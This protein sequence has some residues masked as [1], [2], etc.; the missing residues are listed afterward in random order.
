MHKRYLQSR[1]QSKIFKFFFL[2]VVVFS[3]LYLA[4]PGKVTEAQEKSSDAEKFR[5]R[6]SKQPPHSPEMLRMET[7]FDNQ[8]SSCHHKLAD[9]H[10]PWAHSMKPPGPA[11]LTMIRQ[12]PSM[13]ASIIINGVPGT[14]MPAHP[15]LDMETIFGLMAYI[16]TKPKNTKIQWNMPWEISSAANPQLGEKLYV[17][18][19]QGCHG[20]NADGN[21]KFARNPLIWPKPANLRARNSDIGRIFFLITEGRHGTMMTAQVRDL[22]ETARWFLAQYVD[23]LFD[24]TSKATIQVPNGQIPTVRNK[25]LVGDHD[26]AHRGENLYDLYCAPCHSVKGEGSFLAPMLCDRIWYIGDGTDSALMAILQEGV[27]GKLMIATK[28]QLSDDERW[29]LITWLRHRGSLP[30]PMTSLYGNIQPGQMKELLQQMK[31]E[32]R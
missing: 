18:Y 10:G 14:M 26:V 19:C 24:S 31:G 7:I 17:T 2:C 27:P 32:G 8:C 23:G 4:G 30:D 22:S 12:S 5:E 20:V 21:S 25:Y 16:G 29:H 28:P 1:S 15:E 11:N 3:A 6:Q 13:S 9:G